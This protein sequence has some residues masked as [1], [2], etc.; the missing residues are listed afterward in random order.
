[1]NQVPASVSVIVPVLN[2]ARTIGDTLRSL[3][4]QAQK[5]AEFEIL[6]VDNGSTDNTTE[7]IERFNIKLLRE[8]KRGPSAARNCGL[9][10]ARGE[11]I[12]YLDA[13]TLPTRH[14]LAELLKPFADAAVMLAG[15]RTLA[16]LPQTPAERYVAASGLYEPQNNI[17]RQVFPFIP[18]QNL[19]VARDAALAVG[20][21]S[22]D[23]K[24]A[25]DV[26]FCHRLLIKFPGRRMVY[27]PSAVLFHRNRR[28]DGELKEQARTYGAGAAHIYRRYPEVVQWDLKKSVHLVG[29]ALARF[30]APVFLRARLASGEEV[31]FAKYQK[32]WTYWFWRGFFSVYFTSRPAVKNDARIGSHPGL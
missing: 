13:D 8:E 6:A 4:E 9:R 20:G 22:E 29:I 24:A 14:W 10:T 12:V 11:V 31:E 2:G 16:Y 28:S 3:I 15:G 23:L 7:I 32:F 5:P 27:Q 1:V 25:E 17:Q 30:F 18:S 26:D 21:W 19:A